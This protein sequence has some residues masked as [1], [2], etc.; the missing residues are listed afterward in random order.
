MNVK[1]LQKQLM[2]A[3]AM[4]LVAAIA[5]CS[6]TYAWFIN[7]TRVTAGTVDLTATAAYT[8]QISKGEKGDSTGW[9]T[10]HPWQTEYTVTADDVKEG[11]AYYNK[12]DSS[13]S[14][15]YAAGDKISLN[16]AVNLIP[17]STIGSKEAAALSFV[18][19]SGWTEETVSNTLK[20]NA[21]KFSEADT[22]NYFTDTFQIKANQAC[23]LYLDSDTVF[24]STAG[25]LDK[26]LRLALLVDD[27]S[28]KKTFIYQI[29][30]TVNATAADNTT[31]TSLLSGW[32][33]SN[34][35]I[36]GVKNAVYLS[37]GNPAAAAITADNI[38][39]SGVKKLATATAASD[40]NTL[41]STLNG[42]DVLYTFAEAN[43]V[44]N[45]TVYIW[46]EGCDYDCTA[47]YSTNFVSAKNKI[48]A[49]LSFAAGAAQ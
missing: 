20:N 49:S 30:D 26:V 40:A 29:D 13:T 18:K 44:V 28:A 41:V 8:L 23:N 33:A 19:D 11:G 32:N 38:T 34:N 31:L 47:D 5:L 27:G 24:T 1:A 4:V 39:D 48:S 10:T 9:V 15:K 2:A 16:Q 25:E 12:T 45:V 6:A 36:D 35:K 37:N 22:S 14:Q 43:K 7:N 3:I 17:V 46:M 42:A 21:S